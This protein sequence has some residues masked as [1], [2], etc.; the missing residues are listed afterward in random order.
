MSWDRCAGELELLNARWEPV[1]YR[2]HC[3]QRNGIGIGH[4]EGF[5]ATAWF[6]LETSVV[7]GHGWFALTPMAKR[8]LLGRQVV[9]LEVLEAEVWA[10]VVRRGC[11]TTGQL[12]AGSLG[13]V[14]YTGQSL[15]RDGTPHTK[16]VFRRLAHRLKSCR[17]DWLGGD[18]SATWR[19]LMSSLPRFETLVLLG[20]WE[21]SRY[22]N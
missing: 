20:L 2:P 6:A 15:R 22:R 12:L 21:C 4:F 3:A 7:D 13:E 8:S 18:E 10:V 17:A 11:G 9:L 16:M 5:P 19:E 1:G 14:V